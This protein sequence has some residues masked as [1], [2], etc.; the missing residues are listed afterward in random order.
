ML[1]INAKPFDTRKIVYHIRKRKKSELIKVI[2]LVVVETDKS[3][4]TIGQ[5]EEIKK[6]TI[7]H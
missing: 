2:L 3:I 7:L 1:T 5:I 4:I 6:Y